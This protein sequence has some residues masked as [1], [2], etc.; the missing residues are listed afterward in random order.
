MC[1]KIIRNAFVIN[2]YKKTVV[3]YYI[4]NINILRTKL[5]GKQKHVTYLIIL[6]IF[7]KYV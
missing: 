4:K 7:T 1:V 6:I 3:K 5:L 2:T